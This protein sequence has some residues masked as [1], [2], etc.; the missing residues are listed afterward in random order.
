MDKFHVFAARSCCDLDFQG[1]NPNVAR[2]TATQYGD[3]FCE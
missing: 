2:D 1:S 3:N